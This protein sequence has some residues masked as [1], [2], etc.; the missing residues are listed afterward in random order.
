M[1][2]NRAARAAIACICMSLTGC[3]ASSSTITLAG[4]EAGI[5]SGM[6]VFTQSAT[7]KAVEAEA[8]Q[9]I[10]QATAALASGQTGKQLSVTLT[11]E[12]SADLLSELPADTPTWLRGI[13][14]TIQGFINVY[15][16]ATP[17][18][19]TAV[20]PKMVD[21]HTLASVGKQAQAAKSTL[22]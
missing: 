7:V 18:A 10:N 16:T 21:R 13:V 12:F 1:L 4:I 2:I 15:A 11:Q 20:K 5:E 8:L 22:R 3:S 19:S 17:N 14:A 9:W 6:A